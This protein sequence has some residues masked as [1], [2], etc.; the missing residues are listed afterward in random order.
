VGFFCGALLQPIP[1]GGTAKSNNAR[2]IDIYEGDELDEVQLAAWV[3]QAAA[4]PGWV[5]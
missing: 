2:W 3:K 4:L 1:P 5:A